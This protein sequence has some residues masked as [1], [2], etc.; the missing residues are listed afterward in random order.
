MILPASQTYYKVDPATKK[1]LIDEKMM[2]KTIMKLRY[3]TDISFEDVPRSSNDTVTADC[4]KIVEALDVDEKK[5]Y[6]N[7]GIENL[8]DVV[9]RFKLYLKDVIMNNEIL[10]K[11]KLPGLSEFCDKWFNNNLSNISRYIE[12]IYEY[13]EVIVRNAI[14]DKTSKYV[15]LIDDLSRQKI[16]FVKD[17]DKSEEMIKEY[18][19]HMIE[20]YGKVESIPMFK[21]QDNCIT[22]RCDDYWYEFGKHEGYM[23]FSEQSL[24][25]NLILQAL[26]LLHINNKPTKEQENYRVGSSTIN[27]EFLKITSTKMNQ[28]NAIRAIETLIELYRKI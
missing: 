12:L 19:K 17:G 22:M 20:L 18:L 8:F 6:E 26:Y 9:S 10:D 3:G 14:T 5:Y 7:S 16:V 2:I 11:I 1:A 21:R 23:I 15:D 13:H 24:E 27:H 4:M 25:S 28:N